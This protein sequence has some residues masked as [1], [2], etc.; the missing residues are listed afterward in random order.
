MYLSLVP[1]C[2][3]LAGAPAWIQT[4]EQQIQILPHCARSAGRTPWPNAI[5]AAIHGTPGEP[6]SFTG[7][8]GHTVP[9]P[10][11]P[12]EPEP[13]PLAQHSQQGSSP[14]PGVLR[15]K[16]SPVFLAY[17][18]CIS[19]SHLGKSHSPA[20]HLPQCSSA[21]IVS[22]TW[23]LIVLRIPIISCTRGAIFAPND[24]IGELELS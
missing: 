17:T 10:A 7:H 12:G 18:V 1:T 20:R 21:W 6:S 15:Q 24:A 22:H 14:A 2:S 3:Q 8:P 13:E 4:A 16:Y 19:S 23:G 9:P 5:G 11:L